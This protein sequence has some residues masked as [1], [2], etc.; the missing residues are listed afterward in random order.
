M[1]Q[2]LPGADDIIDDVFV[3]AVQ[4]F[5][6]HKKATPRGMAFGSIPL[7]LDAS[8]YRMVTQVPPRQ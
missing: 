7:F 8:V 5:G 4:S 3:Y 6:K 1:T 2:A